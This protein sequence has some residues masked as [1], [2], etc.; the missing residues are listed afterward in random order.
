MVMNNQ[1]PWSELKAV[2]PCTYEKKKLTWFDTCT[3][4]T[5]TLLWFFATYQCNVLLLLLQVFLPCHLRGRRRL[6]SGRWSVS[7]AHVQEIYWADR[8]EFRALLFAFLQAFLQCVFRS[9]SVAVAST[10]HDHFSLRYILAKKK[11]FLPPW[12]KKWVTVVFVAHRLNCLGPSNSEQH[13]RR[14][15][16]LK[17]L[18]YRSF[19]SSFTTISFMIIFFKKKT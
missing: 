11:F 16:K 19:F 9:S 12:R 18:T 14:N 7:P 6:N 4:S 3:R 8:R 13:S 15:L 5:R 1:K 17:I 10:W 2:F